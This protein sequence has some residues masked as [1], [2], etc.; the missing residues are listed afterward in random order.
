MRDPNLKIHE[1]GCTGSKGMKTF[2]SLPLSLSFSANVR[3]TSDAKD[4][5][6]AGVQMEWNR[7]RAR[8]TSL[9]TWRMASSFALDSKCDYFDS[10][11]RRRYASMRRLCRV[12]TK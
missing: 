9:Y 10:L 7:V 2:L 5:P 1:N 12:D 4:R 6:T 11:N 3:F 8:D